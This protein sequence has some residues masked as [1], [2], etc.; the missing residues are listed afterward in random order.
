MPTA[1][2]STSPQPMAVEP[3][4]GLLACARECVTPRR[5]GLGS[6]DGPPQLPI[7]ERASSPVAYELADEL[8]LEILRIGVWCLAPCDE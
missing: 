4:I 2:S 5:R 3:I 7:R 6:R 1:L 8:R